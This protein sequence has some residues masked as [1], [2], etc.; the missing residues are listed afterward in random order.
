M[1]ALGDLRPAE[2]R[3]RTSRFCPIP[4]GTVHVNVRVSTTRTSEH[5]LSPTVTAPT[6]AR[7]LPSVLPNPMPE[8]VISVPPPVP[9]NAGR[10]AE[11]KGESRNSNALKL[12]AAYPPI[13]RSTLGESKSDK[14]NPWQM[15]SS[16]LTTKAP[17]LHERPPI[18]KLDGSN[19]PVPC[20]TS[21]VDRSA[22]I[23]YGPLSSGQILQGM[24]SRHTHCML[25]T[26]YDMHSSLRRITELLPSLTDVFVHVSTGV[27]TV[28]FEQVSLAFQGPRISR[29]DLAGAADVAIAAKLMPRTITS[30]A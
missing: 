7:S 13:S 15:I 21:R 11:T 10:T 5:A 20:R 6:G 12:M 17:P 23:G 16:S 9:P 29:I 19:T 27:N 28:S 26:F 4:G 30:V 3:T 22:A 14:D 1:S 8:I 2:L 18:F 25:L 24:T